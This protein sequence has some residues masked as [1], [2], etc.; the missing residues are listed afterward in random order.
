MKY[1]SDCNLGSCFVIEFRR[2]RIFQ[3]YE[4]E[5]HDGILRI[6]Y[7][8]MITF[9]WIFPLVIYPD[10]ICEN[11]LKLWLKNRTRFSTKLEMTDTDLL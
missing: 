10:F 11:P 1:S 5:N 6:F 4:T 7:K 2:G 3:C 9:F 8:L